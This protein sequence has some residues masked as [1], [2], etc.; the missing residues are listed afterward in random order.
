MIDA[1]VETPAVVPDLSF[2]LEKVNF[3]HLI[4][5]FWEVKIMEDPA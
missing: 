4:V 2:G 1:D 5:P 3:Q